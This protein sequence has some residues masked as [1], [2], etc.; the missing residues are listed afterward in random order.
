MNNA[1]PFFAR[2][3]IL[4]RDKQIYGYEFFYR[5]REGKS[6]IDDP[7]SATA[8]VL[9]SLVN[10]VGL[11][12]STADAIAFINTDA[13]I[14]QSDILHS[15]PPERFVFELSTD[16][17]GA[18]GIRERLEILHTEGF[19]FAVD[20]AVADP[21]LFHRIEPLLPHIDYVKFDTTA[22]DIDLLPPLLD[23][24]EGKTLVA[25]RVEIPEVYEAY[26][27]LGF[28]LFQ[29]YFFA[30][31]HLVQHQRIDPKHLGVLHLFDMVISGQP[32]SAVAEMLKQH[33][34]LALQFL[35]Y[36]NSTG[37][38][39]DIRTDSFESLLEKVGTERLEQWLMMIVYSKSAQMVDDSK[40]PFSLMIE[41]RVDIMG[42][43]IKALRPADEARM[44]EQARLSAFISMMETVLNVPMASILQQL[45]VDEAIEHALLSHSGE[46][47]R[48]FALALAV[49]KDDYAAAQV[50]IKSL[51]LSQDI[52]PKLRHL[53][54]L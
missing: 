6:V 8:A 47:G 9:V 39:A 31:L 26:R 12:S 32:M 28:D 25:Q 42:A 46:L 13:S 34:E 5:N 43:V 20:N 38:A 48:I 36:L 45:K 19:R 17:L 11:H 3:P 41:Q 16:A 23:A 37:I 7:R 18:A 49:E 51:G 52:L 10:Q 54:K 4:D 35:Q 1:T 24:L 14:L 33:N 30:K 22:T 50:L 40:S 44:C 29:G 53:R 27:D 15:L 21:A 2:Q